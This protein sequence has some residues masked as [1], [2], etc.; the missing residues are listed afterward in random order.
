MSLLAHRQLVPRCTDRMQRR[1]D[2][3]EESYR[4]SGK[5]TERATLLRYAVTGGAPV[6]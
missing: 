3:K 4:S 5:P 1:P 2:H 6:L